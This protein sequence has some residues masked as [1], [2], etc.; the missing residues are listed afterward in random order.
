[1]RRVQFNE[2]GK[3][4]RCICRQMRFKRT[5]LEPCNVTSMKLVD[6]YPRVRK[7]C[8]SV[9]V[10]FEFHELVFLPP[11]IISRSL[12][13]SILSYVSNILMQKDLLDPSIE[14]DLYG[15]AKIIYIPN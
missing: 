14:F 1:M 12:L 5:V 7:F 3:T 15:G 9:N 2:S 8:S 4:T 10:Y 13:P 11:E 6:M